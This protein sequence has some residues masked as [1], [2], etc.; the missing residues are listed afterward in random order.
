MRLQTVAESQVFSKIYNG[1]SERV[2]RVS[3]WSV[4]VESASERVAVQVSE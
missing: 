2:V 3:G 1:V 4:R